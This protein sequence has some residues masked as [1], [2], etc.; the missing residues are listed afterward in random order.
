MFEQIKL[1]INLNYDDIRSSV[2]LE[3]ICPGRL[4]GNL[5]ANANDIVRTTT[6]LVFPNQLF[7]PI[8]T[9]II[10][11]ICDS[12]PK[13][14][15]N[16]NNIL[17]EEYDDRYRTMS[18][19]SDQSIDLV[20]NSFIAI[21][22]C[23]NG[24]GGQRSLFIKKKQRAT[25]I[26]P[27]NIP[28]FHNS[29]VLFSTTTNNYCLHKIVLQKLC[30]KS[31]I[32]MTL[33]LSKGCNPSGIATFQQKTDFFCLR[34]QENREINF[35]WPQ[36][37][38]YTISPGDLLP[39]KTT[40]DGITSETTIDG[41]TSETTIDGITSETTIDGITSETTSDEITSEITIDGITSEITIYG[42]TSETT[43][44]GITSN[45]TCYFNINNLT[46]GS[47][48]SPAFK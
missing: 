15:L 39:V 22:S 23:F 7:L 35:R 16:F 45:V 26:H 38:D 3:E 48:K 2:D 32:F 5:L 19:H 44:D 6:P 17:V 46:V 31:C 9:H 8:H 47:L 30:K 42:I 36:H 28:L 13:H 24:N 43:I 11:L 14:N 33:R 12:F 21:F 10:K 1:K 20:D 4:V 41:I 34:K 27:I 18:Y 37:I 40:I 29:V 25:F